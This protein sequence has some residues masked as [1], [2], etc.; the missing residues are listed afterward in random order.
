PHAQNTVII[1]YRLLEGPGGVR[2]RL[3]PS[4]HFRSYEA[5][6]DSPMRGTPRLVVDEARYEIHD[7]LPGLP[8]LRFVQ[9]GGE[10]A[11]FVIMPQRRTAIAYRIERDRGYPAVGNLWSPGYLRSELTTDSPVALVA[12][13]EPWS[14]ILGMTPDEALD[15]E[16]QR[17]RRLIS[18]A[19]DHSQHGVAAE[20]VL[21]AD[22]F[23]T[24]PA[25]RIAEQARAHAAGRS[26]RTVIAGYHWFTDWGR[27]TMISLEGLALC[28][29]RFRE[30]SDIMRTF[31]AYVRDGLIPN[32]FPDHATE[33]L[34]HTADA[35]LWFFHA[36]E[37]YVRY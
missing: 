29:G 33:G 22:Q 2:L 3:R 27:D 8:P 23:I 37:R 35:T 25:G 16:L 9:H 31:A 6:V 5:P 15:I 18:L 32:M 17:R 10:D 1:T 30:A 21:A 24:T 26:L 4:V 12:S 28:T 14:T 13:T 36:A 11:A 19:P 7:D 20:L 34:Y